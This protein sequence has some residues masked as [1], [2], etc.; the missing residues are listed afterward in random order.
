VADP[1]SVIR[2]SVPA[3]RSDAV[4]SRPRPAHG[5]PPLYQLV[6]ELP[7]LHPLEADGAQ[8]CI[9]ITGQVLRS[10]R[11]DTTHY[12]PSYERWLDAAGHREAYRFHKRLL[13]HL[14]HQNDI[15]F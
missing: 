13:R 10:M 7:S 14:Q 1:I 15:P 6:P 11:F 4:G 5:G 2:I 8:E 3:S 12:V 9:E